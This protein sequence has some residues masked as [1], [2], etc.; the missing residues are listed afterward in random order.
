RLQPTLQLDRYVHAKTECSGR[1]CV[2]FSA[3]ATGKLLIATCFQP[4]L[5]FSELTFLLSIANNGICNC[6]A[7]AISNDGRC[8]VNLDVGRGLLSP[9][10][11]KNI[12]VCHLLNDCRYFFQLY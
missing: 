10:P 8:A 11:N 9:E 4:S 12:G 3:L 2:E 7:E 1:H 6:A 5:D